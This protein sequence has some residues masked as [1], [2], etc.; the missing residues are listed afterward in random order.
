MKKSKKGAGRRRQYQ[1]IGL[2]PFECPDCYNYVI[3]LN[4]TKLFVRS[5]YFLGFF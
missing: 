5:Q 1:S 2:L 4:S 3:E